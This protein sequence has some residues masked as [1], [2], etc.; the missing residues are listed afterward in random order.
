MVRRIGY[1]KSTEDIT[2]FIDTSV[3]QD[4][5]NA[6]IAEQPKDPYYQYMMKQFR[7]LNH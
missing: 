3:Y 1:V 2:R 6:L 4:A 5:L 7:D